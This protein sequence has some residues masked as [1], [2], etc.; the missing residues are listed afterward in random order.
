MHMVYAP[1]M[2]DAGPTL[3]Q[4]VVATLHA[5][6]YVAFYG[7]ALYALDSAAPI[8]AAWLYRHRAIADLLADSRSILANAVAGRSLAIAGLFVV[9]LAVSTWLRAG[10][11]RSLAGPLRLRP[12]DARQFGRL[13]AL[14]LA[15]AVLGALGTW[16]M[17]AAGQDLVVVDLVYL[18]L[19]VLYVVVLY[20]D[21]AIVVSDIGPLSGIIASLRTLRANVAASVAVLLIVTMI[22]QAGARLVLDGV[23]GG[24]AQALPLLVV[25]CVVVGTVV[26]AADLTLVVIYQVTLERR[27]SER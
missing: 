25:E 15:L 8:L 3:P 4:R 20:A 24:L 17:V 21:Y 23:T 14:Y 19:L 5:R 26:F 9:Y 12:R 16:A 6:Q 27:A 18:S 2:D 10:Y 1:P 13:L 7:I 11:I 22:E